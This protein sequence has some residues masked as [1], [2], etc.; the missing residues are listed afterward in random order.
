MQNSNLYGKI[1]DRTNAWFLWAGLCFFRYDFVK[2]LTVD[3]M[4]TKVD[5]TYLDSG[6]S[7]YYTIYKNLEK[8]NLPM[9]NVTTEQIGEGTN[10]HNDYIQ[11]IDDCWIHLINGSN[12]A[13]KKYKGVTFILSKSNKTTKKTPSKSKDMVDKI[14]NQYK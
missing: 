4:P 14:L 13:N 10:Y 11:Y 8:D 6:G 5:N 2:N 9:C 12:W 7:N 3:F 1:V